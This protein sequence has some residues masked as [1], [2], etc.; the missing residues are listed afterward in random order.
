MPRTVSLAPAIVE[1]AYRSANGEFAWHRTDIARAIEA[2]RVARL[3]ILGWEVWSVQGTT[4]TGLIPSVRSEPPGVWSFDTALREIAEPW[5]DYCDRTASETRKQI[6]D[7][8][9]EAES[10]PEVRDSLRFNL[11]Y[12][13]EVEA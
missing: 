8:P 12:V 3:A 4:W 6:E 9:V 7:Q 10:A 11:T 1:A 5:A 13:A 2:I